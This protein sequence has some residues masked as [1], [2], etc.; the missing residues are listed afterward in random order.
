MRSNICLILLAMFLFLSIPAC[1]WMGRQTGKATES[2]KQASKDFEAGYE[3]G[4]QE[5]R[6]N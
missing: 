3:A 6:N 5:V 1:S 4:K 2:V